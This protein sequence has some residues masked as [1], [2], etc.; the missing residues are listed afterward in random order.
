MFKKEPDFFR[1]HI[2]L[3][4]YII[5]GLLGFPPGIVKSQDIADDLLPVK[6]LQIQPVN[7]FSGFL[8]D[9]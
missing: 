8:P 6:V 1:E 3:C 4:L 5:H 9:E 2:A 7:D